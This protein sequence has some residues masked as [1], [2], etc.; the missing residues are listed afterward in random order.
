[1]DDSCHH[2][3]ISIGAVV[4]A[5]RDRI[6]VWQTPKKQAA[7]QRSE[8]AKKLIKFSGKCSIR[9]N[10]KKFRRHWKC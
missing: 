4:L 7:T 8:A 3:A 6:A 9:G 2:L 1:M 5:N 10:M